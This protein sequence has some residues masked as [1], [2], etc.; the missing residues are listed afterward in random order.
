MY[1]TLS[2]LIK[3]FTLSKSTIYRLIKADLFPD[4]IPLSPGRV[5]WRKDVIDEWDSKQAQS[6]M[7][8]ATKQRVS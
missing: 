5:G 3:R 1:L 6:R 2:D 8:A 4:S 7:M